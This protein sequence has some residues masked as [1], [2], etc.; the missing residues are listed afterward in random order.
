MM[1]DIFFP[2]GAHKEFGLAFNPLKAIIS[3]RPIGW[4]SS[5]G[6]DG[7]HNLAPYSFF[8]AISE[9][10]PMLAFSSSGAEGDKDSIK[11][12][13]ETGDFVVNIVSKQLAEAMNA[14]SAALPR[15]VSEFAEA[16]L[17]P[18]PS[19]FVS[20]PHVAEAPCYLECRLWRVLDLPACPKGHA[21]R[22]VIGEV[23]GIGIEKSLITN[24]GKVDVTRYQ[25]VA[26]LGYKDYA[27][28]DAV[29][30]LARLQK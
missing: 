30:E 8:N 21:N 24:E 12:I 28:I 26:R 17:T 14:S 13:E 9:T 27:S 1:S 7:V 18:K 29:F 10:P 22:L 11:N 19:T 20:A 25:P 15:N 16:K 5:I 6:A 4:I 23:L 2:V 3:P